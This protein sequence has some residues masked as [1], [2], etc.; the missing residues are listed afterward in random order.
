[1]VFFITDEC[2]ADSDEDVIT[3][4]LSGGG[5]LLPP[6]VTTNTS[7]PFEVPEEPPIDLVVESITIPSVNDAT[8]PLNMQRATGQPLVPT[9]SVTP[10]SP[11]AKHYPVLEDTL[12]QL[13]EI[14]DTIQ[15][16]RDQSVQALNPEILR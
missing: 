7:N 10:H 13:H 3:D 5:A 14:H 11:A 8:H 6:P 12:R 4:Y 16:M 1:M 15:A 9:I 2:G